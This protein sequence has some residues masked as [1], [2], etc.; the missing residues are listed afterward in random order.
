MNCM[1]GII[2]VYVWCGLCKV[3]CG[4]LCGEFWYVDVI[5]DLWLWCCGCS[6][7]WYVLCE[8]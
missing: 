3:G 1:C 4:V 5:E 8:F 7:Y 6:V 2:S